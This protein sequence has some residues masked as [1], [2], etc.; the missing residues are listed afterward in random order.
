MN[1]PGSV[2][3][4]A[5]LKM[6]GRSFHY[7]NSLRQAHFPPRRNQVPAHISLFHHLPGQQLDRIA[8]DLAQVSRSEQPFTLC[9]T[10]LRSLGQGVAYRL[11]SENAVQLHSRLSCAW[12][13]WLIPQDRQRF[14]PHIT[15][16]NKADPAQARS[17]HA[18]LQAVFT[19]FEIAAVG[20]DLWRY[21]GG[22]WTLIQ[23][24]YFQQTNAS[25]ELNSI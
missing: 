9:V 5:T 10:G 25:S 15:I 8:A 22:P 13:E 18:E 1:A 12:E 21:L 16:Q 24:F 20:I 14:A 19:P 7:F 11:Q 6:D 17:L 4:L 3:L 2:V 23:T